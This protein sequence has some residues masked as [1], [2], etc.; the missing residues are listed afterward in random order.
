MLSSQVSKKALNWFIAG[1]ISP[2][3]KI[4]T[5]EKIRNKKNEGGLQYQGI[6]SNL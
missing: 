2:M 6:N 4:N 3:L 5:L 1:I